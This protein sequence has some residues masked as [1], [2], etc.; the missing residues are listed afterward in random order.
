MRLDGFAAW[1]AGD[2]SGQLVTQPFRCNGDR[3]FVNADSQNGSLAVEVLDGKGKTIKGFETKSCQRVSADTLKNQRAGWI[4][5]AIEKDLH[6]VQGQEIRLRFTLQNAKLY[7]C[8]IA[9]ARTVNLPVP[10][11]TTK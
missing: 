4:Q 5:W 9:N 11:A 7:S 6:R 2:V 10:R 3:L 8:R 1:K